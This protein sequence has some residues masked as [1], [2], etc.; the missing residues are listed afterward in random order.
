MFGDRVELHPSLGRAF[1][2]A[3][4]VWVDLSQVHRSGALAAEGKVSPIVRNRGLLLDVTVTG[5]L[6]AWVRAAGGAW[7][8]LV[9]FGIPWIGFGAIP[10][11]QLL[12]GAAIAQRRPGE[13]EP[14]F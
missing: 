9:S 10:V 6:H 2:P 4:P 8:A 11:R 7:L 13:S 3:R 5:E 14:P 12:P 1:D